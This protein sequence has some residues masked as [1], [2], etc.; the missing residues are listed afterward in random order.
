[1]KI[2]QIETIEWKGNQGDVMTDIIGLGDDGLIY[3]W[4]KS[5]GTWILNIINK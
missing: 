2:I 5:V 3:K 4:N 1:M